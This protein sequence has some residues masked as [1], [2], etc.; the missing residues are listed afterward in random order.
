MTVRTDLFKQLEIFADL[1]HEELEPIAALASESTVEDDVKLVA[2]GEPADVF[3]V[4]VK[5]KVM[6][7]KTASDGSKRFLAHLSDGEIFGEMSV[8]D[9]FKRSATVSS[10]GPVT[11]LKVE[12]TGFLDHVQA[13]PIVGIKVVLALGKNL[14]KQMRVVTAAYTDLADKMVIPW[15]F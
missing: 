8:L 14:S 7:S 13:N 9:N 6:V 4:I 15:M 12:K 1:T 2:E 3:F 10:V 5:G 11:V